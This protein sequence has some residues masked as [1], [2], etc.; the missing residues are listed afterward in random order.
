MF[1]YLPL[2]SITDEHLCSSNLRPRYSSASIACR[3]IEGGVKNLRS[4]FAHD[5]NTVLS[6]LAN[7]KDRASPR[8]A[9]P[10]GF[11]VAFISRLSLTPP[12]DVR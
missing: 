9:D 8:T 7:K 10:H 4:H 1:A 12:A 5:A 2:S 11:F 3:D 6:R